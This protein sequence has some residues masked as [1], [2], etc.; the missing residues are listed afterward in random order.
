M[1]RA[2]GWKQL[3]LSLQVGGHRQGSPAGHAGTRLRGALGRPRGN[4]M[5]SGS[6]GNAGRPW[7]STALS[8]RPFWGPGSALWICPLKGHGGAGGGSL[9]LLFSWTPSSPGVCRGVYSSPL[10]WA[11][12]TSLRTGPQDPGWVVSLIQGCPRA[13]ASLLPNRGIFAVDWRQSPSSWGQESTQ[14]FHKE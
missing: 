14:C 5:L 4:A 12:G 6:L 8:R 9:T 13:R 3:L 11:E 2:R 7:N 1:A 10:S